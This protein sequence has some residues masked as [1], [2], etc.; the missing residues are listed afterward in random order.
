MSTRR[1]AETTP[2]LFSTTPTS[3]ARGSRTILLREDLASRSRY[4]LPKDLAGVLEHSDDTEVDTLLA[5]V[6]S[7]TERRGR[8]PTVP[9]QE[10]SRSPAMRAQVP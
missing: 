4:L 10:Q 6:T 3:K 2:D 9:R 7:K 8:L 1:S 5:T